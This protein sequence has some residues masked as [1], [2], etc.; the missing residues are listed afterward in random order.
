[1]I[2]PRRDVWDFTKLDSKLDEAARHNVELLFSLG[3]SPQWASSH[4]E[5]TCT[6]GMGACWEPKDIQDWRSYIRTVGTRYKGRVHLYEVWNEPTD[7]SFWQGSV[8]S[9]VLLTQVAWQVLKEVDPTNK[10]ITPSAI[11][12]RGIPWLDDFLSQGG[13]K[14][15]DIIGFH[16]YFA[17]APPESVFAEISAVRAVMGNHG[18]DNKPLWDTENTWSGGKLDDQTAAAYL[19]RMFILDRAAGASRVFLY[20]WGNRG[21]AVPLVAG[22]GKTPSPAGKTFLVLQDWLIGAVLN[23]CRSDDMPKIWHGSHSLWT[24]DLKK[25]GHLQKIM[26]NPDGNITYRVPPSW[27]INRVQTIVGESSSFPASGRLTVGIQP[28]LLLD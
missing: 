1:M 17:P 28:I 21:L 3:Y 12:P 16:F 10:I 18:A 24:C 8:S 11:G 6:V 27:K 23:S 13:G 14:Y 15:A 26:W 9:L 22:D 7:G 25:N 4:P 20:E 2:E 19:A 5:K